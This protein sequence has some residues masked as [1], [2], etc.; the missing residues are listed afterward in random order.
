MVRPRDFSIGWAGRRR[1][2]HARL[3]APSGRHSH[4]FPRTRPCLLGSELSWWMSL[5]GVPKVRL[6]RS[7]T[8]P[9]RKNA[10]GK[11]LPASRIRAAAWSWV[12]NAA[13]PTSMLPVA[14]RSGA[15]GS[16]RPSACVDRATVATTRTGTAPPS[17]IAK[18]PATEVQAARK[19]RHPPPLQLRAQTQGI[20]RGNCGSASQRPPNSKDH[21][22][23]AVRSHSQPRPRRT[24]NATRT[25]RTL[26]SR[27]LSNLA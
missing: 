5:T 11:R 27:S 22:K 21:L 12:P 25:K 18:K 14:A 17:P 19:P 10:L 24:S 7:S 16:R 20:P 23:K 13:V 4:P 9:R 15:R 3:Q 1:R 2:P 26:V 6:S 8:H